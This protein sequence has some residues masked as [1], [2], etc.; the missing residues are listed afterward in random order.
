MTNTPS[1]KDDLANR[2]SNLEAHIEEIVR[3][4]LSNLSVTDPG[5][6]NKVFQIDQD[7]ANSN[8]SRITMR[9]SAGDIIM[10]NDTVSGWGYAHPNVTYAM[11]PFNSFAA[12]QITSAG[13][14]TTYRGAITIN[15][16]R[17]NWSF[18]AEAQTGTAGNVSGDFRVAW[19]TTGNGLDPMTQMGSTQTIPAA[20]GYRSQ[21]FNDTYLWPSNMYGQ[22]VFLFFQASQTAGVGGG[23][24]IANT[25]NHIVGAGQ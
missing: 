17:L 3:K 10:Q 16:P 14:Q 18:L 12:T 2:V 15:L 20:P 22:V 1:N 8:R 13:F 6:G 24:W 11:Y 4:T 19:N 25:P 7:T 23:S 21:R 9:D 5:T